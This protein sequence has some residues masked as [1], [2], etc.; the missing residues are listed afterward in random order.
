MLTA[1][2]HKHDCVYLLFSA[3]M[4]ETAAVNQSSK[5]DD[6]KPFDSR[7][8]RPFAVTVSVNIHDIHGHLVKVSCVDFTSCI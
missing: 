4:L 7:E 2:K 5:F 8:Y 6:D 3:S 1:M